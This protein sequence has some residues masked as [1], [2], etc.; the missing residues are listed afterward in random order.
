MDQESTNLMIASVALLLGWLSFRAGQYSI[1]KKDLDTL[2]STLEVLKLWLSTKYPASIDNR[3]WYNPKSFVN[4]IDIGNLYNSILNSNDYFKYKTKYLIPYFVQ[5][6]SRFNGLVERHQQFVLS[7]LSLF[8][9]AI[10]LYNRIPNNLKPSDIKFWIENNESD[11]KLVFYSSHSHELCH[12]IHHVGIGD[13]SE[14]SDGLPD[15]YTSF[16][17]LEDI[18]LS[19]SPFKIFWCHYKFL[20]AFDFAVSIFFIYVFLQILIQ[21]FCLVGF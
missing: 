2:K 12:A 4:K 19:I 3:N 1:V 14:I 17:K 10:D 20:I 18:T 11:D 16:G 8:K 9:E 21:K 6:L 13:G 5:L 15:L 7:D